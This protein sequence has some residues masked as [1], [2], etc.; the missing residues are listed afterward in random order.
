MQPGQDTDPAP[1]GFA[2]PGSFGM[3]HHFPI[4]TF[5]DDLP[6][7]ADCIPC[8]FKNG[9]F[10]GNI[11]IDGEEIRCQTGASAPGVR[12]IAVDF[13]DINGDRVLDAVLRFIPN[14]PTNKRGPLILPL[15]RFDDSGPFVSTETVLPAND[16]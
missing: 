13:A 1:C 11:L 15:T 14:G 7:M 16:D 3:L 10:R 8:R 12:L 4:A 6:D 2:Q 5:A 9:R